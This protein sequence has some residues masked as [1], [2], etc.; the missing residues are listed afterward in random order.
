MPRQSALVLGILWGFLVWQA[1]PCSGAD[2]LVPLQVPTIQEAIDSALPG[3]QILV[4]PGTYQENINFLGKDVTL[5][6]TAGPAVTLSL[7][8]I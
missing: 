1:S 7:I 5:I 6:S 3:D 2:W 8:H 4:D